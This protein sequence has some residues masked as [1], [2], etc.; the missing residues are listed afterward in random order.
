MGRTRRWR[1]GV[2]QTRN[3]RRG[4]MA[5]QGIDELGRWMH[6]QV[7]KCPAGNDNRARVRPLSHASLDSHSWL[8]VLPGKGCSRKRPSAFLG[9]CGT[10]VQRYPR[11]NRHMELGGFW[12]NGIARG[13]RSQAGRRIPTGAPVDRLQRC[14]D[15][16]APGSIEAGHPSQGWLAFALNRPPRSSLGIQGS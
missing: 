5:A 3:E 11:S 15:A 4:L 2:E 1:A 16:A 14:T 6:N 7:V 10:T 13:C 9:R 12:R 8:S